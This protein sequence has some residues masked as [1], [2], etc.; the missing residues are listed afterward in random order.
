MNAPVGSRL[1]RGLVGVLAAGALLV[2]ATYDRQEAWEYHVVHGAVTAVALDRAGAEGWELVSV[3]QNVRGEAVRTV[4][5]LRGEYQTTTR[6]DATI[7]SVFKRP[8][9]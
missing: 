9:R 3:F 7:T 8:A 6:V 2:G 4:P 1:L 5:E